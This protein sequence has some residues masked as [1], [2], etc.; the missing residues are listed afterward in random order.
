MEA[1]VM[2]WLLNQEIGGLEFGLVLRRHFKII[3]FIFKNLCFSKSQILLTIN[4][5]YI[6]ASNRCLPRKVLLIQ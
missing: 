4:M 2:I 6:L 5:F 3:Y 1:N